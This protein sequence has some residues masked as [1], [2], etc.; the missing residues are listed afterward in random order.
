MKITKML[1]DGQNYQNILGPVIQEVTQDF[2][3]SS[4]IIHP[5]F[6]HDTFV[7]FYILFFLTFLLLYILSF[8][9]FFFQFLYHMKT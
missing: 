1:F 6:F 2:H 7:V 4:N 8:F 9:H 5:T 3:S